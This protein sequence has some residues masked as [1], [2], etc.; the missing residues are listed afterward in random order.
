LIKLLGKHSGY[1]IAFALLAFICLSVV[2]SDAS[3]AIPV[4]GLYL[5]TFS[6]L[7]AW[8]DFG[9]LSAEEPATKMSSNMPILQILDAEGK[10]VNLAQWDGTEPKV[11]ANGKEWAIVLSAT[12]GFKRFSFELRS[13]WTDKT[14]LNA[15]LIKLMISTL[16]E[17]A[18]AAKYSFVLR[19]PG[20]GSW[21]SKDGK[22]AAVASIEGFKD[23][24][25]AYIALAP[26]DDSCTFKSK[27]MSKNDSSKVGKK[28]F[29][30]DASSSYKKGEAPKQLIMGVYITKVIA[31]S[32]EPVLALSAAISSDKAEPDVRIFGTVDKQSASPGESLNYS[33]FLLNAGMDEA[34]DLSVSIPIQEKTGLITSSITGDPGIARL[35]PSGKEIEVV[36]RG[37]NSGESDM[38]IKS[39]QWSPKGNLR[40]GETIRISFS[41]SL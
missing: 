21:V 19:F 5:G 11:S 28:L 4:K 1:R 34:T 26:V 22:S 10:L 8:D 13:S 35:M 18:D 7:Q 38:S 17:P 25:A 41:I 36:Q 16:G 30:I 23:S 3:Q 32:Y 31:W 39:I 27:Q 37:Q 6:V 9:I 29:Y 14:K 2:V 15:G 12:I 20:S 24:L 40:P 33:Y